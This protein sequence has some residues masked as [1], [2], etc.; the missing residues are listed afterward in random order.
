MGLRMASGKLRTNPNKIVAGGWSN[1]SETLK[2]P[3][4][5][6]FVGSFQATAMPMR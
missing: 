3:L 1:R 5:K 2:L 4:E 6:A